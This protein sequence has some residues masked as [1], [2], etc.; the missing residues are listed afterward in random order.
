MLGI[1]W[2]QAQIHVT[3]SHNRY[4]NKTNNIDI[5]PSKLFPL[6]VATEHNIRENKKGVCWTWIYIWTILRALKSQLFTSSV[7]PLC[8]KKRV[9]LIWAFL[10][11]LLVLEV[12]T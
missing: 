3:L 5:V 6:G 7:E 8:D 2:I 11:L 4:P 10:F 9:S 12:L 1:H